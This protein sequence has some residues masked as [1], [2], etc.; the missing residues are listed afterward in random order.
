MTRIPVASI[1]L[2]AS[3]TKKSTDRAPDGD[4]GDLKASPENSIQTRMIRASLIHY[5]KESVYCDI[6]LG[7]NLQRQDQAGIYYSIAH[8]PLPG[9]P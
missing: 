2:P 7:E 1:M 4:D 3:G 9:H 8:H 5:E 6:L